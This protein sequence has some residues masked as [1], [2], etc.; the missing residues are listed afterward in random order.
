MVIK[1]ILI[2]SY[3]VIC[4][5]FSDD[6]LKKSQI[7][8]FLKLFTFSPVLGQGIYMYV[9]E[10]RSTRK[11]VIGKCNSSYAAILQTLTAI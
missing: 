5:I 3:Y 7:L 9:F 11:V 8:L 10:G 1:G 4:N 6:F 2:W